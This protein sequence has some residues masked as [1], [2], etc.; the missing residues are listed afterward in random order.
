MPKENSF[1]IR[2]RISSWLSAGPGLSDRGVRGGYGYSPRSL[3]T[4]QAMQEKSGHRANSGKVNLQKSDESLCSQGECR[5][6]PPLL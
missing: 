1:E 6:V 5:G 2:L 3:F 4:G